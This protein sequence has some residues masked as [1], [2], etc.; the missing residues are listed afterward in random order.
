MPIR[1]IQE[2]PLRYTEKLAVRAE[3]PLVILVHGRAGNKDV[4]WAFR[5]CIPDAFSIVLPEAPY[6]D[7][8]NG[9][10]SWWIINSEEAKQQT[11][12][13]LTKLERFIESY[14]SLHQLTP[15][16]V[17]IVGFSQG[18][19]M[20]SLLLQRQT[21]AHLHG[22]ALLASFA[23]PVENASLQAAPE[24]FLAHGSEDTVVPV[25]KAEESQ[26]YFESLGCEV[27]LVTDP[28]G[29]KVG[30]DG[31]KALTDWFQSF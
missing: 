18:G 3:M 9:G 24:V 10:K 14:I 12:L 29:H 2:L 28:V 17:V 22:V 5:R 20:A 1:P 19:A 30:R 25:S 4:M 31:M 15:R 16:S 11:E 8:Y 21:I 26:R 6:D 7:P 13:S 27:L 23:I